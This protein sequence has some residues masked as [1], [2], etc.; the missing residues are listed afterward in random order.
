M[1]K[2]F[3]ASSPPPFAISNLRRIDRGK[4]RAGFVLSVPGIAVFQGDLFGSGADG[5]F[6]IDARSVKDAS[7]EY[8]RTV[9]LDRDFREAVCE[10]AVALYYKKAAAV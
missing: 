9:V 4:L 5:M 7:G 10:S 6:W 2:R 3:A 8:R 1:P